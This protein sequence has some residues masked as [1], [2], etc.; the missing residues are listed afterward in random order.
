M[1][2]GRLDHVN[3]RT[4]NLDEMV[5]WYGE[6]MDMP[7]GKR[8]PFDFPGAWLYAGEYAVVHLVGVD[9]AP[10]SVDPGIEHFAIRATGL[11]GFVARLT[12]KGVRHSVDEV[13]GFPIVQVNLRDPDGNHI[14]VD[15]AA[16][17]LEALKA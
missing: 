7:S 1:E 17:E 8:P 4:G 6:V 10:A 15:F 13:P 14:H 3:I 12:E 9:T 11:A 2:L 5:R 16:A